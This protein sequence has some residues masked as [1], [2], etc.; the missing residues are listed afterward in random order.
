MYLPGTS[1]RQNKMNAAQVASNSTTAHSCSHTRRASIWR[2]CSS[3]GAARGAAVSAGSSTS[4][5][6]SSLALSAEEKRLDGDG[7]V[8]GRPAV[9]QP[10]AGAAEASLAQRSG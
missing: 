7:Q 9:D 4:T 10:Q 8:R 1:S 3:A 6:P 2:G 5:L